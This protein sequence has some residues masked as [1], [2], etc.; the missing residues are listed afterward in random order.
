MRLI[1]YTHIVSCDRSGREHAPKTLIVHDGEVRPLLLADAALQSETQFCKRSCVLR[2]LVLDCQRAHYQDPFYV[3]V[4]CAQHCTETL[5]A[6][7]LPPQPQCL[8][9]LAFVCHL[10]RP[11]LVRLQAF[12]PPTSL[13]LA[14]PFE[15]SGTR[16]LVLLPLSLSECHLMRPVTD[17]CLLDWV[18]L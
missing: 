11:A 15:L 14:A 18:T 6:S 12:P 4:D 16:P 9:Q 8:W 3:L 2:P 1:N 5:P 13:P 7:H 10:Q 17:Y